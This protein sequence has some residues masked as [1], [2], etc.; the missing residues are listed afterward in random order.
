MLQRFRARWR[1]LTSLS[2][3]ALARGA[4]TY[5]P[6]LALARAGARRHDVLLLFA[7]AVTR[8]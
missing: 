4:R 6:W 1:V 8:L 2:K 7:R 5:T 3:R